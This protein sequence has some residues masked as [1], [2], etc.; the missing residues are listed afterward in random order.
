MLLVKQNWDER[1]NI[2]RLREKQ[3]WSD[4]QV[5]KILRIFF[6]VLWRTEECEERKNFQVEINTYLQSRLYRTI[7][8]AHFSAG[9]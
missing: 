6:R 3:F 1:E 4:S 9:M 5:A 2:F 7:Y 8:L